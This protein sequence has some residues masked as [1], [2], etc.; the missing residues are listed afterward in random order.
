L[1]LRRA[2][3]IGAARYLS[4][5]ADEIRGYRERPGRRH[6]SLED[7]SVAAWV[8]FYKPFEDTPNRSISYYLKGNLVSLCL[9]LHL[10]AA[11]DGRKS[12]E[13]AWADLWRSHG[14]SLRGLEEDELE[15]VLSESTGVGLARFFDDYVRGTAEV[16]F[17]RHLEL[18][19]LELAP[20]TKRPKPDDDAE[21][22]SLGVDVET[23]GGLARITTVRDGGAGRQAGLSPGDEI[24]AFDGGRVTFERL[25]KALARSPA[26]TRVEV[27]VFRRGRL[28]T[29]PVVLGEAP[30]KELVIASAKQST[31][32][33]RKLYESWLGESWSP[34][35]AGDAASR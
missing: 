30:P 20:P 34:P 9:D 22:G 23:S 5:V 24:L 25:P 28:L 17:E 13:T 14:R 19:G 33:A 31:E 7:A 1:I 35:G 21:P 11:T 32:G 8:D 26:G 10:R 2:G 12:L 27:T 15:R 29:L 18:V 16:D 4:T 3:R 6:Q